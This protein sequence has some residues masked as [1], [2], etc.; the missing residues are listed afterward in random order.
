MRPLATE[1]NMLC[2]ASMPMPGYA[3]VPVQQADM[4][5]IY[6][7]EEGFSRGTIFPD[8]DKPLGVYGREYKK[9]EG[10]NL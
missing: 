5:N 10:C 4:R 8:L 7:T 3:Y 1:N 2:F 9:M 6:S